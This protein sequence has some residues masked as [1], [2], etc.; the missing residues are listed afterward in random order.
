MEVYDKYFIPVYKRIKLNI[1]RAEG[2]YLYDGET[3]YLDM[4]SGL[5][6][7][8]LG[9]GN[10]AIKK[11]VTEQT[12]RYMHI[13][14][15]FRS[16]P[17]VELAEWICGNTF[18][19]SVFFTN[20]GTEA[21]EAGLK[22]IRKHSSITGKKDIIVF[23][24]AF[25]GRTSGSASLSEPDISSVYTE[26][27]VPGIVRLPFNSGE[28]LSRIDKNTAGV[29]IETIQGQGGVNV[30]DRNFLIRLRE[31]T[32]REGALLF[33]DEIQSGMGRTGKF[34]AFENYGIVPD[35]CAAAKGI[36]GGLPLGALLVSEKYSKILGPGEHGSTFGGNP[37]SCAAGLAAVR[38]ITAS[39]FLDAVT[40]KGQIL[41][42]GLMKLKEE[43]P[44]LIGRISG[45][46]LMTGVEI[47]KGSER[48]PGL[49]LQNGI[50]VNM[51]CGN[52][53][54]LL[55]P[56]TIGENELE[57]FLSVFGAVLKEIVMK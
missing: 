17:A 45:I 32:E 5:G 37:V 54:R 24:K 4:F 21:M 26:T 29:V 22:I 36:G 15:Y 28:S 53:L 19:G 55:P 6:V 50:L 34:F 43:Y 42:A 27:A 1:T 10:R 11:A 14:N 7:N 30:A 44:D 56:L 3:P 35:I 47:L 57:V 38:Q 49:F 48:L 16:E 52:I 2:S 31:L 18:A 39:G 8:V 20:S 12:G 46:G 51:T 13:S 41:H 33:I 23:S 9:H 40:T 25:H